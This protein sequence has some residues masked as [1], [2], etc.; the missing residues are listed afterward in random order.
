MSSILITGVQIRTA[1]QLASL[2]GADGHEIRRKNRNVSIRDVLDADIVFA[3]GEP[4]LYLPLLR[5]VRAVDRTLPFIVVARCPETPEWLDAIEAGATDYCT[6]PLHLKQVRSLM[7]T[8][9]SCAP[10]L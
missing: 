3:G 9:I 4:E 10:F 8:D 1:S 6:V 2:L 5:Q 7:T